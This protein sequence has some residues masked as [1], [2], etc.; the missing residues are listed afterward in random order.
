MLHK[1][2]PMSL[3]LERA[4]DVNNKRRSRLDFGTSFVSRGGASP[5][6]YHIPVDADVST[7]YLSTAV[8]WLFQIPTHTRASNALY[9]D[10]PSF[11]GV[12]VT[13]S[14]Q[15][16]CEESSIPPPW[17]HRHAWNLP[18]AESLRQH[19]SHRTAGPALDADQPAPVPDSPDQVEKRKCRAPSSKSCHVMV[20]DC[21]VA[22][23]IR[24]SRCRRL[25]LFV[26]CARLIRPPTQASSR[27]LECCYGPRTTHM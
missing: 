11:E 21:I 23:S 7:Q 1:S 26:V 17:R 8:L 10:Q 9:A 3:S 25:Q 2:I 16:T 20:P 12:L 5:C 6:R 22:I 13:Q 4:V 15:G 14:S 24:P 19:L 27:R 18:P